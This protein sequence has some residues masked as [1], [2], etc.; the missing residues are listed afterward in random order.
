[1]K[2]RTPRPTYS[3]MHVL[4]ASPT[5][6]MPERKRLHQLTAMWLGLAA[7]EKGHEPTTNDWRVCSDAVNLMETLVTQG[8]VQDASGLLQE[9]VG[10]LAKA[11]QR[12]LD[13]GQIR[14]DGPGIAAVRAVLEDY[15]TALEALPER[16]MVACHR[17]TEARMRE[18]MAGKP[19]P[20]DVKV[21]AI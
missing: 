2:P 19:Q 13:G 16:T 18:I 9:A 7:L 14:L 21:M 5:A 17:K 1:M 11:S 15:A 3:H 12:Y 8:A 20:H 6:P 10:A 4:M